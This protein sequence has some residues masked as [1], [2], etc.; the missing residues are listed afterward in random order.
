MFAPVYIFLLPTFDPR[1]GMPYS[2]RVRGFDYLGAVLSVAML[3]CIIMPINFGGVLYAWKSGAVIALFV[4]GG[5][6][7]ISFM[8]QQT[9]TILTHVDDRMFPIQFLKIKEAVLLFMLTS[10]SNAAGFIAIYYIP[11][12]FQFA[13]GETPL[14]AAVKLLPLI[15]FISATILVN[16]AVMGKFTYYQPWYVVGSALVLI[17]GVLL[18]KIDP[19]CFSIIN[20][21][22]LTSVII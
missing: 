8:V 16:G 12:Y 21:H 7:V 6:L 2:Q 4:V 20:R 11:L 18:C 19:P 17:G 22:K 3:I 10:A 15:V 1:K 9:L 14:N 5:L 13:K